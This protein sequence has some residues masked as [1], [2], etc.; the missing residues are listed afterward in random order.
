L[1]KKLLPATRRVFGIARP[2]MTLAV[3]GCA[4]TVSTKAVGRVLPQMLGRV[5][6]IGAELRLCSV[7]GD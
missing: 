2:V 6:V 3:S 1:I 4:A 5:P 7:R